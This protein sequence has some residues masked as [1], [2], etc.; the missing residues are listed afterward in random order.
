[1]S[2]INTNGIDVNYPVP[3]VNNNSQGFRNNFTAIKTNLDTAGSE[4]TDL[5]NK[6]VLKSALSNIALNN[7]MANTLISNALTR[8]FRASTYNLGNSLSGTVLVNASLGDVQYGNISEDITLQ[9]GSWA[10]VGTQQ[11]IILQLGTS[12]ANATI[13]WPTECLSNSNGGLS[14]IENYEVISNVSTNTFANDVTEITLELY[15]NDCGNTIYITPLN[16]PFQSTQIVKRT[17]PTTGQPGDTKGVVTIGTGSFTES[18]VTETTSTDYLV[19]TD[20]SEYYIGLPVVFTGNSFQ[21][22]IV[23]GTT[24]YISNIANTT[25]FKIS[26]N[27]NVSGNVDLTNASG[28]LYVNPVNYMYIAVD[29]YAANSYN[30]IIASTTAPNAI[31]LSSSTANVAVNYPVI[32]VGD[33]SNANLE[34]DTVYYINSVSGSTITVSKTTDNG[35]AGPRLEN[36]TTFTFSAPALTMDVY[37]GLD[38]F[39]RVPLLP[40]TNVPNKLTA[41]SIND[42]KIFGGTNGYVLQ[43]DGAGNLS[44]VVGGGGGGGSVAGSNTQVQFNDSGS[45]GASANL[46]FDKSTNLLSINGNITVANITSSGN[47]TTANLTVTSDATFSNITI[48]SNVNITNLVASGSITATG[49]ILS[50]NLSTTGNLSVTGNTTVGGNITTTARISGGT[51]ISTGDCNVTANVNTANLIA[52]GCVFATSNITSSNS[53]V[54][55]L[56]YVSSVQSSI[57]ANGSTQATANVLA[58]WNKEIN[59]VT[60]VNSGTGVILPPSVAGLRVVIRNQ[61]GNTLLVYPPVGSRINSLATN[62]GYSLANIATVNGIEFICSNST[63]WFTLL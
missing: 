22:N 23:T 29:D 53:F 16:R 47:I 7:D 2:S 52:S 42:V 3:G 25:H 46:T 13:S 1:M 18:T 44:W 62:A 9:F 19:T 33:V 4:I 27:A 34:L 21:S 58:T 14:L 10:P 50:G 63:S 36:I 31:T 15:T 32:F 49:D 43:T 51:L 8:S 55:N 37:D 38:I 30:K 59:I 12:N 26:G 41:Q 56:Y 5:Q 57:T 6:A 28:N 35:K 11:R 20:T 24:Y 39:K 48:S 45:F 54:A 60:S 61:G 40:G 17:P